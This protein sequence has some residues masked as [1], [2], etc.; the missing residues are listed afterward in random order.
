MARN[1]SVVD[2]LGTVCGLVGCGSGGQTPARRGLRTG[3]IHI[4]Y[5]H[6]ST[7]TLYPLILLI[8]PGGRGDAPL[9]FVTSFP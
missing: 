4:I 5:R 6:N 8:R 3:T 7:C 2:V 9:I 1:R